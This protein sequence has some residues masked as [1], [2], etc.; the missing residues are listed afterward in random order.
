MTPQQIEYVLLVAQLRSFS[1]AAQKLYITQPS[2]SKYIINIERQLGTEIFD[3]ST[4]PISL[5]AAGEAYVA[6]A[7]Q[8]K[9]AQ[10]DLANRIADMQNLRAGTLK[11][12][13]S[14]FRTS[15]MLARSI[16]QFCREHAGV[17]VSIADNNSENLK[18]MLRA[19]QIDLLISTGS[20]DP[21]YFDVEPLATEQ[22]YAAVPAAAPVNGKL[23]DWQLS[24]EDI[25]SRSER[26]LRAKP[27][28]L[29]R[30]RDVPFILPQQ[31]E[32]NEEVMQ[33]SFIAFGGLPEPALRVRT[34][35]AAFSFVVSGFGMTLIPDTMIH[36]GNYAAHPVFYALE[37]AHAQRQICLVMRR[38]S[39]VSKA[40]AAYCLTLKRLV[41]IGTWRIP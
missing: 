10:D 24:W 5:T 19:G 26:F 27:V 28:D 4:T 18:E 9:A 36:F 20:F 30:L 23:A 39:Y 17:E 12:G 25:R 21:K 38:S 40:A 11:I 22:L 8:I 16:S 3:R 33:R 35:D 7:R 6:T 34:I 2:L 14:T 32:F 29:S 1:K 41:E 37:P 13:T 15:Y 31:E